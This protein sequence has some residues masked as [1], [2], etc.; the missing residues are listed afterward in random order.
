MEN[1]SEYIKSLGISDHIAK[2]HLTGILSHIAEFADVQTALSFA[3]KFGG[4]QITLPTAMDRSSMMIRELGTEVVAKLLATDLPMMTVVP[5]GP[6]SHRTITRMKAMKMLEEGVS[7]SG[8]ANALRVTRSSVQ[9]WRR[10]L[11]GKRT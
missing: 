3:W 9:K 7:L 6:F 10:L 11:E 1:G 8:V 4:K 2:L 5:H